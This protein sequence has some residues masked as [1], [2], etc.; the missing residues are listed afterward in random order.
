[1]FVIGDELADS[2]SDDVIDDLDDNE[3]LGG[4]DTF[5]SS[6]FKNY[7]AVV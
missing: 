1:M 5:L 6:A 4:C 3:R 2:V 7:G